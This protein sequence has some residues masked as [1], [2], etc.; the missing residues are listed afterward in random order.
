LGLEL[1]SWKCPSDDAPLLQ[2]HSRFSGS[3]CPSGVHIAGPY[4]D[5]SMSMGLWYMPSAGPVAQGESPANTM[6]TT[7]PYAAPSSCS[8]PSDTT[9][10]MRQRN[11][12]SSGM[13]RLERGAPGMFTTGWV[14]YSFKQCDDGTS[15][16]F[17]IGENLPAFMLHAFLFHSHENAGT[18]NVLPNEH[19][20]R[21]CPRW[22]QP[23]GLPSC[24]GFM[25][26]F[27]SWHVG[28]VNM[29]MADGS[30]QFIQDNIDY[31]V[32][33]YLGDKNDGQAITL[34]L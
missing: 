18:T 13:G 33:V 24:G 4:T 26:G 8:V 2:G 1:P 31:A 23:A 21:N 34:G 7:F 5:A 19:T 11:C 6:E 16:T 32:W 10:P 22:D 20:R 15:N 25:Q 14:Q 28:G 3:G 29:G 9:L 30:G 17:L 27:K 12:Q